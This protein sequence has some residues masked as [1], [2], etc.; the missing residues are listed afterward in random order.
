MPPETMNVIATRVAAREDASPVSFEVTNLDYVFDGKVL[1]D[2][3]HHRIRY[4]PALGCMITPDRMQSSEKLIAIND[5]MDFSID[6]FDKFKLTY[7]YDIKR[8]N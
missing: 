6:R 3:R 2:I 8:S 1:S 7:P 4:D 5:I